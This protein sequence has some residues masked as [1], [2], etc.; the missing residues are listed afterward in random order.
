[1]FYTDKNLY[2][3]KRTVS[4]NRSLWFCI[5]F[6]G[7]FFIASFF[8]TEVHAKGN[9]K[10]AS[11]VID[12][13]T[14]IVISESR[15]DKILHPA[16]ITKAMT[17]MLMFDALEN[18]RAGLKDR[19]HI[20][21]HAASMVPSKIGLPVGGTIK[22]E[23]AI[24]A[25]VTK[26]ANDI[27]AAMAEH[28][29]GTEKNFAKMM[30]KKARQIGMKNTTFKN[31]SGLHDPGQVTTVRDIAIMSRV[32]IK[33]YPR[34]YKYFSTRNFTFQGKSYHNHNR[35]MESYEGMDGL[36]TGYINASGFN[37]A[38]SAVRGNKRLIGVVFGGRTTH[39]RNA[40]MK[41]LLDA[42]VK[43]VGAGQNT[44]KTVNSSQSLLMSNVPVPQR[45]PAYLRALASLNSTATNAMA[46]IRPDGTAAQAGNSQFAS[47]NVTA[48]RDN[49]EEM[50]GGQGDSDP[51]ASA[52]LRAGMMAVSAVKGKPIPKTLQQQQKRV[53]QP[54]RIK[55]QDKMRSINDSWAIQIGAFA[56]R[57]QTDIALGKAIQKLPDHLRLAQPVIVPTK[58][59]EAWL[60]R[61][62]LNGYTEQQALAACTHL[63]DCIPVRPAE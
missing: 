21:T 63:K 47:L 1:M 38:A 49:Y 42:G 34:Y 11:I 16:S 46:Q 24:L 43:K 50:A 32:L 8:A 51:G 14:G 15:P 28:L 35:L 19:I 57:S 7:I 22:V 13:D 61:A 58:R 27:A 55:A 53:I 10:Y 48:P 31:A 9:P 29:G 18:G 5:L 12:A 59:G 44:G 25:L 56:S 52:R 26:S 60:F 6:L 30:T 17:L 3:S 20:S 45:K 2:R 54:A 41:D 37:L 40:H 23:D 62:R 33:T 39:S 36:K 4:S